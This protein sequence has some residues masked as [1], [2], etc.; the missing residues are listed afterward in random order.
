MKIGP[1]FARGC[2]ALNTCSPY[3][4]LHWVCRAGQTRNATGAERP[5]ALGVLCLKFGIPAVQPMAF[6]PFT[7]VLDVQ[8][9]NLDLLQLSTMNLRLLV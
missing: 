5:L 8:I 9:A 1:P 7:R 6:F 2:A 3:T 4:T